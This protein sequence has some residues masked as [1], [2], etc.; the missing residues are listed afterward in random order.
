MFSMWVFRVGASFILARNL[1]MGVFGVW[2]AMTLDWLVRAIFFV[3]RYF[4]GRWQNK[5]V[6]S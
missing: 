4:S 2:V 6:L 3:W 5:Q 1:E